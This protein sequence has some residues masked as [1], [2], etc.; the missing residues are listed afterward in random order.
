MTDQHATNRKVGLQGLHTFVAISLLF[1]AALNPAISFVVFIALFFLYL[2]FVK[3][4]QKSWKHGLYLALLAVLVY[5][6]KA[7]V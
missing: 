1:I 3:F 6:L 7:Y 2:A 5:F 4:L